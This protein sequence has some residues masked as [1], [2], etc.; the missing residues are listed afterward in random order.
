[1]TVGVLNPLSNWQQ[2]WLCTTSVLRLINVGF[3]SLT[4]L[5]LYKLTSQ[6]HGDKHVSAMKGRRWALTNSTFLFAVL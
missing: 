6:I 3:A 4:M 1:M 5:V 2:Q